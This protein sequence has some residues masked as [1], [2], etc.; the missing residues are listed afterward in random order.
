VAQHADYAAELAVALAAARRAGDIISEGFGAEHSLSFKKSHSDLVTE[1]DR[2]AEQE[3]VRI[4]TAAFP[5][6]QIVAEEGSSGGD[7]PE[8]CWYIDPIDGTT[9]FAHAYPL[10]C[11]S[12]G[13]A[14]HGEVVLGVVF[15]PVRN[16]LFVGVKGQGATLN[17]QPIRVS[18]TGNLRLGLLATGF[19]YDRS[20]VGFNV[21]CFMAF[22][23][24][25][26]GVRR[27]GCAA[28]DICNVAMG[29]FDGFWEYGFAVWDMAAASVIVREAGG[30][31][32][33]PTGEPLYS[34]SRDVVVS[35]GL[36]HQDIVS[37]LNDVAA[38]H[39]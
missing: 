18:N 5:D 6:H 24:A 12:I 39:T 38:H 19:P 36:I 33:L 30:A 29:R 2:R 25:A 16:E 1:F 14:H 31:V 23:N 37:V 15:S 21:S 13:M 8:Y 26:Q 7:Q 34:V 32:T 22:L 4:I 35:N 28:L 27:D 3:I 9:N 17:G 11:T 20:T 10:V